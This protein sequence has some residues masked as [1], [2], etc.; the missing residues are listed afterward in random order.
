MP[1]PRLLAIQQNS[2]AET[3]CNTSSAGSSAFYVYCC[4][5]PLLYDP[6]AHRNGICCVAAVYQYLKGACANCGGDIK[7]NFA[8]KFLVDKAGNVVQRNGDSPLASE[9]TIQQLLAA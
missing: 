1:Q 8:A 6:A 7:W 2:L 4:H 3:A 9:A 5:K